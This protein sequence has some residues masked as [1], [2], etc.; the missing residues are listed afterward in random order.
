MLVGEN[1]IIIITIMMMMMTMMMK[2]MMMMMMTTMMMM[3]INERT[4]RDVKWTDRSAK[5]RCRKCSH[6]GKFDAIISIAAPIGVTTR[7]DDDVGLRGF[8]LAM[9]VTDSCS[10]ERTNR[11]LG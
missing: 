3:M 8:K 1:K 10:N 2:M 5:I 9:T 4:K 7:F 11:C 6:S